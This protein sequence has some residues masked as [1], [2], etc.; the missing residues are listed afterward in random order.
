MPTP[1]KCTITI[2]TNLAPA[3][4][5]ARAGATICLA[6]G[7]YGDISLT[8]VAKSDDVIVQPAPGADVAIG[9]LVF[10]M[11][12]HLRFTGVGGSMR[13]GGL[14][15]DPADDDPTWSHDLTFDHITWTAGAT[16][17]TRGADQGILFESSVFDNLPAPLYEGR[18][19]VRGYNNTQPVGVTIR[20]SHFSGGCSDG[21][22][23]VGDAYGVQIGP[24]NEFVGITQDPC[25]EHVDPI[26]LYGSRYTVIT[27]NF[28]HDNSTAVMAPDGGDHERITNN[29]FVAGGYPQVLQ[30]GS[31]RDGLIAHNTFVG[32]SIGVA[33]HKEGERPSTGQVVRDN[34]FTGDL[35][36]PDPGNIEHHNLCQAGDRDCRDAHD[37][38]GSPVFVGGAQP[39]TRA[40]FKLAPRSPGRNAASDGS[41]IGIRVPG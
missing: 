8:S 19:T 29:V 7:T 35:L 2:A 4:Q 14:D 36:T 37:V 18:V 24:G 15:L 32:G 5:S 30:L 9:E 16:V 20:N 25:A 11:V 26:Q 17:R 28:F 40:G 38:K 27:G 12:S 22:Q 1:A 41:D 31:H 3:I 13:I 39:T 33:A 21:V 34:I 10:R 23:V 6:S